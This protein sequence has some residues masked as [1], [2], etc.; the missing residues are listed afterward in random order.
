MKPI[1]AILLLTSGAIAQPVGC[2]GVNCPPPVPSRD[3]VPLLA[4]VF[5]I[6]GSVIAEVPERDNEYFKCAERAKI[7]ELLLNDD[8]RDGRMSATTHVDCQWRER[9]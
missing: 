2:M 8:R 4:L 7:I 9:R 6:N 1:I 5:T 3:P